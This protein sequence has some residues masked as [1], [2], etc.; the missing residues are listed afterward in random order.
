LAADPLER[1]NLI[2]SEGE[3]AAR[4][5]A[6]LDVVLRRSEQGW[7]VLICGNAESTTVDLVLEASAGDVSLSGFESG[8]VSKPDEPGRA[9]QL[10]PEL[11]PRLLPRVAFGRIVDVEVPDHAE[12]IVSP[13]PAG[14]QPSLLRLSS[15][16][17][18]EFSYRL[19]ANGVPGSGRQIELNASQ[20][21]VRVDSA[22][23]VDCD[24]GQDSRTAPAPFLR[25]LYVP[26]PESVDDEQLDPALRERLRALGYL[27]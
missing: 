24:S 20:P 27:D 13:P 2:R 6:A 16:A 5:G 1:Q 22:S 15:S 25:I 4:M 3:R 21:D 7:H 18:S 12:V 11:A 17:G 9:W 23:R 26:P 8:E 19:G 14:S 10:R